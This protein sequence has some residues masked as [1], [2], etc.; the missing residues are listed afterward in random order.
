MPAYEL[1][2]DFR[3]SGGGGASAGVQVGF[4]PGF[5]QFRL[6]SLDKQVL[7]AHKT[8]ELR[9]SVVNVARE[10]CFNP[11]EPLTGLQMPQMGLDINHW[12]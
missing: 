12:R 2:R 10:T 9:A 11:A 7:L 5:L 1:G 6:H 3:S 4:I 8:V